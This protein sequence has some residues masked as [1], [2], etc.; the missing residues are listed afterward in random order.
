MN[1]LSGLANNSVVASQFYCDFTRNQS[2][3]SCISLSQFC[4]TPLDQLCPTN[5]CLEACQDIERLYQVVPSGVQVTFQEYG[6]AENASEFVTLYGI[7]AGYSNISRAL[8]DDTLPADQV[9][10]AKPYFPSATESDLQHLT[11]G[12]AQCLSDT[13]A[14][15]VDSSNCTDPCSPAHLLLNSTTPNLAGAQAC[16][17]ELCHTSSGLPFG[18]Q[19]VVG[20]GVSHNPTHFVPF[21]ASSWG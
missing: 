16:F 5:N 7:C 8:N 13:C 15:A 2:S 1:G 21:I 11:N 17:Q 14:K 20:P 6:S 12:V 10:L 9:N 18:N 3:P 19:D 4:T